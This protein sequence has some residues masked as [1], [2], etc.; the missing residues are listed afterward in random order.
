[1][2]WY[3]TV[4]LPGRVPDSHVASLLKLHSLGF[5]LVLLSFCGWKRGQEVREEAGKLGV[6]WH[7]MTFCREKARKGG[8]LWHCWEQK[9]GQIIDDDDGVLWECHQ[10]KFPYYA[11]S[12]WKHP[13]DWANRTF[14]NLP[15]AVEALLRDHGFR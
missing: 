10:N 1:M 2:D 6:P 9:I 8:K 12:T 15:E 13:H 5:Q 14:R 11:I 3:N 4:R 7:S